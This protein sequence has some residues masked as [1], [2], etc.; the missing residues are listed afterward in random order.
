[1]ATHT[2]AAVLAMADLIDGGGLNASERADA[3]AMLRDLAPPEQPDAVHEAERRVIEAAIAWTGGFD[4]IS[5]C[6]CHTCELKRSV[7]A[8][9]AARGAGG[10]E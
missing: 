1:M 3:A 10:G 6:S 9:A 2:R 8:L 5:G 4:A 7:K